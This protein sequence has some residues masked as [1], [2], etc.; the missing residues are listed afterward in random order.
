MYELHVK[1]IEIDSTHRMRTVSVEYKLN[2][3]N[4]IQCFASGLCGCW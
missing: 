3:V 1:T 4:S 2:I